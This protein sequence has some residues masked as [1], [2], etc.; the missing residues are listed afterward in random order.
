MRI[1]EV[2]IDGGERDVE[3]LGDEGGEHRGDALPELAVVDLD[4]DAPVARHRDVHV[5]EEVA[6]RLRVPHACSEAVAALAGAA[7]LEPEREHAADGEGGEK[8]AP[9]ERRLVHG[10][11]FFGSFSS[12]PSCLVS[13]MATAARWM[14][15]RIRG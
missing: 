12:L 5:G 7:H 4:A 9:G 11:H 2:A 1:G 3:L 8:S 14:A 13:F 15:A 10:G 6:A